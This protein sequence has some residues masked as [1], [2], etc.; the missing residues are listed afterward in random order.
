MQLKKA[1][2][3]HFGYDT[4]RKGQEA[5]IQNLL[6]GKDTFVIMPTGAGKSLCFQLPATMLEG[7][8]LVISPLIA[9]MKNQVD[10]MKARGIEARFLNSTLN[11]AEM[12]AVKKSVLDGTTKLLYVAPESL[13]KEENIEFLKKAKLSFVAVDEVH[14][15]SE[16]GHDFRPEYRRIKTIVAE[17]GQLPIIAL[18][19]TATPKVQIDIQKNLNMHEATIFKSSFHRSNLFYEVRPKAKA[20]NQLV[21]LINKHKGQSAII[22]C[23]SRRKVEELAHFLQV[24]GFKALPYHAGFDSHIR[25]SNQDK[26]LNEDCDII[27]ATIAFGMGIDK[28]D[29]RLVVHYDAPKSVEGYYQE[30]GRAGRDSQNS[31]CVMFYSYKDILKLDKFNKDKP[32]AERENAHILLEEVSSYAESPQCRS[33]QLLHYF[34]EHLDKDCGFCDNCQNSPEKF[35]A[36]DD[37]EIA[38]QTVQFVE[39]KFDIKYVVDIVVGSK[40]ANL[41]GYGHHKLSTYGKGKSKEKDQFYW[42][43]LYRQLI[44]KELLEKDMDHPNIIKLTKEGEAFIKNPTSIKLTEAHQYPEIDEDGEASGNFHGEGMSY[45]EELFEKLKKTR[46]KV[47]DQKGLPP[48]VVF[49]EESLKEM[50]TTFPITLDSLTHIQGVGMGKAQKFG[51]EFLTVIKKYTEDNDIESITE[52]FVKSTAKKSKNKILIIQQ[53][54]KKID[55]GEIA[56]SLNLKFK[57]LITELESICHAGTK[58]N[59]D[60]HLDEI[61][62]EESQDDIYDYF[63]EVESDDLEDAMEELGEDYDE[64]AI[65]LMHVKFISE[66]AN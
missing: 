19:A 37:V 62:D 21:Q 43:S 20:K 6:N 8:A 45:D 15:I 29:V 36:K 7:T 18:T 32:L 12:I 9:L 53:I 2:K 39:G 51:S 63:M 49:Q 38:L 30:T 40:N 10:Q 22:Y 17:L 25:E 34:G 44:I 52:I 54:D 3:K 65:L 35:E 4:F 13:T 41:T 31:T 64:E 55:L 11:K 42:Y 16:W 59:I 24:N 5:V 48:Y 60:Y 58:L 61:L 57:N 50:A 66:V 23:L 26:F 33:R 14:C 28:P 1:L 27:V 56:K 46:K 47:A